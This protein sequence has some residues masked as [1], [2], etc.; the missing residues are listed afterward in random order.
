MKLRS[1]S[2]LGD[3]KEQARVRELLRIQETNKAA[4]EANKALAKAEA[5]FNATL[6]KNREIWAL[7]EAEHTKRVKEQQSELER[8]QRQ[9]GHLNEIDDLREKLEDK[10]DAAGKKEQDLTA[11]ELELHIKAEGIRLQQIAK[12]NPEALNGQIS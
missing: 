9:I 11:W 1:P 12:D 8:L 3:L 4:M 2:Q 6:A 5:D 10:L 7:E